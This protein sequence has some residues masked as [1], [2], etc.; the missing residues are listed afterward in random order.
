MT[1]LATP[2]AER[3]E[4]RCSR[5]MPWPSFAAQCGTPLCRGCAIGDPLR[6]TCANSA[7]RSDWKRTEGGREHWN[8]WGACS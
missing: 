3:E 6:D 8:R 1:I 4:E 2:N 5:V 7:T